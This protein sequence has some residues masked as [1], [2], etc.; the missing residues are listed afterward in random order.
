MVLV[1][2]GAGAPAALTRV[3]AAGDP[4]VTGW[5]RRQPGPDG[6]RWDVLLGVLL[7]VGAVLSSVMWRVTGLIPDPAPGWLSVLLLAAQ[8]LPLTVRRRWPSAVAVVTGAAFIVAQLLMVPEQ[9]V[10]NI[11]LFMAL[12]TVGAWERSRARAF[13]VRAGVV[14]AMFTWLLVSIFLAATDPDA[15]IGLERAGAFSPFVAYMLIQLL[16]N[17]LYFAG[18]W[19]FGDHA[20]AS[21]RERERTAWRTRLLQAERVRAEA[22]AVALERLRIARELHDAVAHHVSLMGVQA[23][24]AR[25]VLASDPAR[26]A[27]A[28]GHV[29]E[30][31]R[32]AVV[33]LQ[34]LLGTLREG[35]TA[36]VGDPVEPAPPGEALAS[37]DVARLPQ[38][39]ES[40][41]AAGLE[42]TYQEVGDPQRLSPLASLNL[43]RIAQ[44]ALTN[45]RKH[46]GP[47]ARADVR[48]RWLGGTVELEVSDDGGTGRRAGVVP[49][50]GMGLVGMRERV[51]SDGGTLEAGRLRRGGFLV[52]ARVP[53]AGA[54]DRSVAAVAADGGAG[55]GRTA[56]AAA[57]TRGRET[58]DG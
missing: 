17:V 54:R 51:A 49:S 3:G 31:A 6:L 43:Y 1:P 34:G 19:W 48:L 5:S 40:A 45:A 55:P 37:L 35:A 4:D 27:A 36:E 25:T 15:D 39:V 28:L 2:S 22:Q 11:A 26:A 58:G 29:E 12:Y 57:S 53:V 38:L 32:E 8:T 44:E 20:W 47:S 30:S 16:T 46:A 24:A 7:F 21:A 13:W 9:L 50:T 14:T 41:R 23:A 18:A 42:V 52:R 56:T 33:E 10:S